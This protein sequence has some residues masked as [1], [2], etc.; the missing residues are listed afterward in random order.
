MA[1]SIA[2]RSRSAWPACRAVSSIRCSSIQR[3][4]KWCAVAPGLDRQLVQAL[5]GGDDLPA[6]GAGLL[7]PA[8]QL[9]GLELGGGAELVVGVGV[10][11]DARPELVVRQA[12]EADPEPG[13]LDEGEV[14]EQ[15]AQGERRRRMRL[16]ELLAGE[17]LG[18]PQ[19]RRPLQV[20]VAGQLVEL[21]AGLRGVDAHPADPG[22]RAP[23][24][25]PAVTARPGEDRF[26]V[27]GDGRVR[28][29]RDRREGALRCR[30]TEGTGAAAVGAAA[31]LLSGCGS[32]NGD[33]VESVASAFG[34]ED[35]PAAR[36]QLLAPNV[37]EALVEDEGASCEDSDRRPAGR[38][39][40]RHL[41]CRCGVRRR[42]PGSPT[43]RCS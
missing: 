38:Q 29:S 5:R 7:V 34:A 35:D 42:R 33:E 31:L 20:E 43:T 1:P 40:R 11:V 16:R 22:S 3:R 25:Q 39:R 36:C 23:R 15:A 28:P 19:H 8:A 41:R 30:G 10:P 14:V 32:L 24:G 9:L 26:G 2:S 37:V 4:S 6:A 18:L 27:A 13:V 21:G 17:P 12:R